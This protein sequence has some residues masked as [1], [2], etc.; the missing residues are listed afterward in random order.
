MSNRSVGQ[1]VE[2]RHGRGNNVMHLG[3]CVCVCV[4]VCLCVCGGGGCV[5]MAMVLPPCSIALCAQ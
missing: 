4:C 3:A 5:C 1:D 2:M